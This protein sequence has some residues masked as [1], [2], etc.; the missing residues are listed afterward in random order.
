MFQCVLCSCTRIE[1]WQCITHCLRVTWSFAWH[2]YIHLKDLLWS[3][4]CIYWKMI[5]INKTTCITLHC[6]SMHPYFNLPIPPFSLFGAKKFYNEEFYCP[7]TGHNFLSGWWSNGF[8]F[9]HLALL[10]Y[11]VELRQLRQKEWVWFPYVLRDSVEG[12]CSIAV[13]IHQH[14]HATIELLGN[15]KVGRTGALSSQ[16]E[17]DRNAHLRWWFM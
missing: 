15:D 4:C 7:H 11:L 2:M 13:H 9:Q 5:V 16:N 10:H 14:L 12:W 17:V 1:R 8:A 3:F 6:R